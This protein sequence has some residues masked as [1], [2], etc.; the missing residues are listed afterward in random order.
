MNFASVKAISIPEGAVKKITDSS[1]KVLWQ[2]AAAVTAKIYGVEWDYSQTS[3][4]LTRLNG[5]AYFADPAPA[6]SLT[7]IGSSPFDDIQ[8]WAGTK[9][10]NIIDGAVAYSEDDDGFDMTAYDTMVYIP[11]FYYKAEKDEAAQKWRWYI[12]PEA[13]DGFALHPGSG[14]YIGRYHTSP[15]YTSVSG[16]GP[17][18]YITRATGRTNSHAKGDSWWQMDFATWCALELLY[19]VE[20]ADWDSQ[21]VLGTGHVKGFTDAVTNTGETDGAAYHTLK[22]SGASNMYRNIENPYSNLFT[23]C[24][25][26]AASARAVYAGLNNS[27]FGDTTTR[28]TASGITLPSSYYISGYGC[29]EKLPWAFIPDVSQ[30]SSDSHVRDYIYSNSGVRVLYVG[31]AYTQ[32]AGNGFFCLNASNFASYSYSNIGSRLIYIP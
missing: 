25:G 8:P 4:K 32:S 13:Q 28:L 20:F 1:G 27:G 24:D 26:F 18:S 16:I 5:A 15:A 29:S 14:R 21:T 12:S 22:R 31:G 3:S 2:K 10:Y 23:W 9:K 7:A 30:N 11:P 17:L 6:E 19:L